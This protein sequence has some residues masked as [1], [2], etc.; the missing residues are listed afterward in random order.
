MCNLQRTL[1]AII[2]GRYLSMKVRNGG[3]L[4]GNFC[5]ID[6]DASE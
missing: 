6:G 5:E 1:V 3:H 4:A 2:I